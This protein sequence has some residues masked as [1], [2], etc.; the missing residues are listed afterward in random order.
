MNQQDL[1]LNDLNQKEETSSKEKESA[2][3][4]AEEEALMMEMMKNGVFYGHRKSRKNPAFKNFVFASRNGI[5]LID[6]SFTIKMLDEVAEF[7]KQKI[8]EK[9]KFMVVGTQPAA[10]EVVVKLAKALG[11]CPYV[12]N[13]WIGGLITNFNVLLRRIEYFKKRKRDWEEKMFENY[14]KKEKL[15]IERELGKMKQKFLGL[16]E[17]NKLPEILFIIDSS[18]KGHKSALKEAKKKGITVV[19]IIDNDDNPDDFDYFIPANDHSKPS[20]EWVV[21]KLIEKISS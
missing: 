7:L 4:G 5:E 15:L 20:L 8:Q 16:E 1:V 19:G 9:K 14:T 18:L 2:V 3:S 6:L 10:K 17:Y 13:K 11:N 12:V 21:G